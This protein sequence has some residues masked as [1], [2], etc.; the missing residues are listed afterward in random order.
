MTDSQQHI[1]NAI[2][3]LQQSARLFIRHKTR[4]ALVQEAKKEYDIALKLTTQRIVNE[5]Y[6]EQYKYMA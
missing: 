2:H 4:E 5:Y 6:A 1:R 3:L